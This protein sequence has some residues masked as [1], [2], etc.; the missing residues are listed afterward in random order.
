[1]LWFVFSSKD[2]GFLV[3]W[4]NH[5][6]LCSK[7]NFFTLHF[8]MANGKMQKN[9]I[10]FGIMRMHREYVTKGITKYFQLNFEEIRSDSGDYESGAV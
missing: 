2:S 10:I 7:P 4:K 8:A 9:P 1:M 5:Q 6:T 3:F